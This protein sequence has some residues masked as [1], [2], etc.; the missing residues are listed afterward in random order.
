MDRIDR[1]INSLD[2]GT[3]QRPTADRQA[4][5][6]RRFGNAAD[7]ARKIEIEFQSLGVDQVLRLVRV[8]GR[9]G[10]D[11]LD[12]KR[13]L[14]EFAVAGVQ[15]QGDDM[16]SSHLMLKNGAKGEARLSGVCNGRMVITDIRPLDAEIGIADTFS[17]DQHLDRFGRRRTNGPAGESQA[18]RCGEFNFVAMK[19][20][21]ADID[22]GGF[23]WKAFHIDRNS[24]LAHD[25]G[26]R[27]RLD[28]DGLF[29]APQC[30]YIRE[31]RKAGKASVGVVRKG[32]SDI[33][34]HH[35]EGRRA[36]ANIL[37]VDFDARDLHQTND[38]SIDFQDTTTVH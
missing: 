1:N 19:V 18:S 36:D 28:S 17:V 12:R 14:A 26:P 4:V 38:P 35:A 21:G 29:P 20:E 37:D 9:R 34:A 11:G 8:D 7:E 3:G 2:A 6:N 24:H 30:G 22:L 25:T 33:I 5:T 13:H 10:Q 32:I 23:P 27:L 31:K 16:L 15:M